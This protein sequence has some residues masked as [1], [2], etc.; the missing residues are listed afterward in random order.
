MTTESKRRTAQA[1]DIINYLLDNNCGVFPGDRALFYA[2]TK[3]FLKEF[4]NQMP[5]NWKN[6]QTAVK[7]LETRKQATL[8]THMLRTERGRLQTCTLLIR[9]GV[10][11]NG[12]IPTFMKQ[13]MRE[14]YPGIYIPAPF[15]PTQ[16]ELVLLQELDKKTPTAETENKPN[17]NGQK[18]RSRRKIDEIEVFNAPYYTQSA[19]PDGA[20]KDPLWMRESERSLEGR[21]GR[22]KRSAV[23]EPSASPLQK[24]PRTGLEGTPTGVRSSG[25]SDPYGDDIPVD[26]D[27]MREMLPTNSARSPVMPQIHLPED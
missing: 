5:P 24:R 8:H 18:F 22:R 7:A 12:M 4:R 2:V 21:P 14:T 13:K 23:D 3:V 26:P 1:F 6:C 10:D 17:A 16:E 15:S 9:A 25:V 11:P 20:K 27:I 19:P